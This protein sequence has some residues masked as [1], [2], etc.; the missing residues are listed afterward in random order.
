MTPKTTTRRAKTTRPAA[1]T[2][3]RRVTAHEPPAG[4]QTEAEGVAAP[5][6]SPVAR[7]PSKSTDNHSNGTPASA[8]PSTLS[9]APARRALVGAIFAAVPRHERAALAGAIFRCATAP[10][11][12]GRE[13]AQYDCRDG[14]H[15][16]AAAAVLGAYGCAVGYV[17]ETVDPPCAYRRDICETVDPPPAAL[18]ASTAEALAFDLTA[19]TVADAAGAVPRVLRLTVAPPVDL[20]AL[21]A[22]VGEQVERYS[23]GALAISLAAARRIVDG[24]SPHAAD[25]TVADALAWLL[26]DIG[27]DLRDTA[28]GY[29]SAVHELACAR[30]N[31]DDAT[32]A[33]RANDLRRDRAELARVG[34]LAGR[35]AAAVTAAEE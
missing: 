1:A 20:D 17:G 29:R 19:A 16:Y 28:K 13:A 21:L 35:I 6:A 2:S 34:A 8:Q 31:D 24:R 14:G 22:A 30:R 12:E 26:V 32:I 23:N 25:G 18:D 4:A 27:R 10:T 7:T 15:P 33:R 9:T 11:A 5:A 3:D